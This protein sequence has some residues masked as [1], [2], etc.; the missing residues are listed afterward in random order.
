MK[1]S[2]SLR[3][4]LLGG[5]GLVIA[6][7]VGVLALTW[8]NF[9]RSVASNGW[10]VHT[11]EVLEQSDAM[12]TA[13][14]N[15]ETGQRGFLIAGQDQFL[16]PYT[17]GKASF[18]KA[19]AEAKTLTA[20]NPTQQQRLDTLRT[21]YQAWLTGVVD[22]EIAQRRATSADDGNLSPVIA[23]TREAKG[24]SGMDAM[25]KLLAEIR[26]DETRLLEARSKDLEDL[27]RS[28]VVEIVAGA[29]L[30]ALAGVILAIWQTQSL[31]RQ[32]GGEPDYALQVVRQSAAGDLS[33]EVRTRAGDKTSLLAG[34]RSMRD[35]LLSIVSAIQGNA[36]NVTSSAAGLATSSSQLT[37]S[38]QNQAMSAASMSASI[39]EM[40]VSIS[41]VSQSA[42]D[43]L[44]T[45]RTTG[46]VTTKGGQVINGAINEINEIAQEVEKT[47]QSIHALGEHSTK[48]S[49][50]VQ[51]IKEV[52]DQTNLL[53]L[54]AAIEAARAG[55]MGRGFA[56][57]ADEVRKLAE[58]TTIST[59]EIAVMIDKVQKSTEDATVQMDAVVRSVTKG[60]SL[61]AEADTNIREIESRVGEVVGAINEISMALREQNSAS[62]S[63]ATNVESVAQMTDENSAAAEKTA[64]AAQDLERLAEEAVAIVNRFRT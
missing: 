25:R 27:Q 6:I 17:A 5:Y 48:I 38:A 59:Q 52:A 47:S 64:E 29:V 39:E 50:V 14:I 18:D 36:R 19:H 45:A 49:A 31:I 20:D 46:D 1:R 55:E 44:N 11:Y 35:E 51:V 2:M 3:T 15:I 43:A 61:A 7:F 54:N 62:Q 26:G 16:E 63:I 13:L 57:V 53:A 37:S 42:Q 21:A 32:L 56:V 9:N 28:T 12:L 41:H 10:T 23:T 58:R 4:R 30:A 40:T 33:G 34:M 24:K 60:Q 22:A 8:W